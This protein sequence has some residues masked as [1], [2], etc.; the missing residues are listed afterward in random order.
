MVRCLNH[1]AQWLFNQKMGGTSMLSKPSPPVLSWTSYHL[2]I[3]Q[4]M[5]GIAPTS[6]DAEKQTRRVSNQYYLIFPGRLMLPQVQESY[7]PFAIICPGILSNRSR[8]PE[9]VWLEE[10]QPPN[11]FVIRRDLYKGPALNLWS[12]HN[13]PRSCSTRHDNC[14]HS[15]V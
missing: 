8:E 14:A 1:A 2:L 5:E 11:S 12:N 13:P 15:S 9:F 7:L 10:H 4:K 3:L 6:A